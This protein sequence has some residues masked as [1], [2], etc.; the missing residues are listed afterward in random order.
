MPA[1]G[2]WNT[3]A[4]TNWTGGVTP[5]IEGDA[6]AFGA[7]IGSSPATVTID[8]GNV[9]VGTLTFNNPGGGSYTLAGSNGS[10]LTLASGARHRH[11]D[12][13]RR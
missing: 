2:V 5:A 11:L 12:R 3:S 7:V 6:A 4:G 9:S 10:G 8:A 13:Q 1:S